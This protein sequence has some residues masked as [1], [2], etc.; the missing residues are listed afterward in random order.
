ME[1]IYKRSE[2]FRGVWFGT[3][4]SISGLLLVIIVMKIVEII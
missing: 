2:Y 1:T 3:V 4:I